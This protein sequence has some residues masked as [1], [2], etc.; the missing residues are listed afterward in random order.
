MRRRT[1]APS[2]NEYK[3]M[4]LMNLRWCQSEDPKKIFHAINLTVQFLD[5]AREDTFGIRIVFE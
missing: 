2:T 5:I 1:G 3:D 4:A